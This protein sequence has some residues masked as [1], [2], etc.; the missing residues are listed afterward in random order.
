MKEEIMGTHEI[1]LILES[2]IVRA[3]IDNIEEIMED[4][5]NILNSLQEEE[6]FS[7]KDEIKKYLDILNPIFIEKMKIEGKVKSFFVEDIFDISS[8]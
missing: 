8:N 5:D 4:V 2:Y 6:Y 1:L 3:T 7:I